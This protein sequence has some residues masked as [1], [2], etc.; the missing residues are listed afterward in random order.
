MPGVLSV[1]QIRSLPRQCD[2]ISRSDMASSITAGFY[3]AV[4]REGTKPYPTPFGDSYL[5]TYLMAGSG[6]PAPALMTRLLVPFEV[7]CRYCHL[8]LDVRVGTSPFGG[9]AS[10]VREYAAE[11]RP[12]GPRPPRLREVECFDGACTRP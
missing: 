1:L 11:L 5:K 2:H 12:D 6:A 7:E 3:S 4:R 8:V 10:V 9:G